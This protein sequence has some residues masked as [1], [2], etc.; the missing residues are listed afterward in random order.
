MYILAVFPRYG[1]SHVKDKTVTR[2]SYLQHGDPYTGKS[3]SVYWDCPLV[4]FLVQVLC[5][6]WPAFPGMGILT[7]GSLYWQEDLFI[8]RRPPGTISS[9]SP[10]YILTVF[11]RYGDSHVKDKMV[12]RRS[13]LQHGDPYTGKSASVYWDCSLVPFLVQVLCIYWPAFPGMG[14]P[15]LKIR[16]SR[17]RLIFNMGIPILARRHLYI[18]T[19]SWYHF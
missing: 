13:C 12:A 7:W 16:R 6:Y 2:L 15:M 10:V 3:A 5:I 11:S 17:H 19:A 4:P 9:T 1:D 14:I 18:E 8:S